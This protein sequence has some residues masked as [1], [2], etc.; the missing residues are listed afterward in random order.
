MPWKP[1]GLEWTKK[2]HLIPQ[3][4]LGSLGPEKIYIK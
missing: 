3:K 2:H 1:K 4:V